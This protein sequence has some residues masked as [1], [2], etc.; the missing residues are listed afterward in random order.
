MAENIL[1]IEDDP[2][3]LENLEIILEEEGYKVT[4]ASSGKEGINLAG[5]I[6]PDLI[7]CDV[8]LPDVNG[9]QVLSH[10]N[11]EFKPNLIPFIFL[12]VKADEEDIRR[13]MNLGADDY[14]TKPFEIPDVIN[15]VKTR[16]QKHRNLMSLEKP[17]KNKPAV[18]KEF[19]SKSAAEIDDFIIIPTASEYKTIN[20]NEISFI[21]S[22]DVYSEVFT[23]GKERF[24]V[25]K[26]LKER[27]RILPEKYFFRIH[28]TA[29]INFGEVEKI[30]K[31]TNYSLIVFMKNYDEFLP[32]SRSKVKILKEKFFI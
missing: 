4:S 7:I 12:T 23:T 15:S 13:G 20:L 30:E 21:K 6:N 1:I 17:G 29:I 5:Q 9:Y 8:V 18:E 10:L 19:S 3:V 14:I 31:W 22:K 32:V 16:I 26:L 11:E 28:R 25:R 27:L 2:S 24:L